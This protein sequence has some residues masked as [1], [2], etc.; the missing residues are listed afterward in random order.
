MKK[1]MLWLF[2]IVM[3]HAPNGASI[4]LI[5]EQIT[6][7]LPITTGMGAAPGVNSQ[8]DMSSGKSYYVKETPD[9]VKDVMVSS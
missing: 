4:Y 3:L 6:A 1:F 8:I 2:I 5:K 7:V 9:Q